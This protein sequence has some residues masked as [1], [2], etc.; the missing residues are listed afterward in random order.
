[1]YLPRILESS[2]RESLKYNPATAVLGPRQCG[3][4]TL[5]KELL[6]EKENTLYLDLERPSD[7]QKLHDPEWFLSTQTGKLICLDEIQRMP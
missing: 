5:V 1:M 6:K 2:I 7:L 3:K 4:S